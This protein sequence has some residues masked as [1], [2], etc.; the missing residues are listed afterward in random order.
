MTNENRAKAIFPSII[1][2]A[3]LIQVTFLDYFRIFGVKPDLLFCCAVIAVLF[4]EPKWALFFG[5]LSGLLKDSAGVSGFGM[6]TVLFSLWSCFIIRL[7][8]KIVIENYF[9]PSA[10]I[11]IITLVNALTVRA[12][13]FSFAGITAPPGIFLRITLLESAYTALI[14]PLVFRYRR[15]LFL[16]NANKDY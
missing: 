2:I 14:F 16:K 7:S 11:F 6:N 9:L 12:V 10:L 13:F 4:F 8:R 1:I 15:I 3:G 5:F